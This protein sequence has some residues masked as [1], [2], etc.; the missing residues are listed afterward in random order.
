MF[1]A[2]RRGFVENNKLLKTNVLVS[3]ILVIGFVLTAIFSYRANYQASLNNIEQVSSL[4][5]EGI[6]YQLASLFSK[7]VNISLTMAHD[8]LLVEHLGK[9]SMH[10]EDTEYVETIK[11][12]LRAYQKKYGFDSVF[13][14][15]TASGRYYNFNGMDRVLEK[16]NPENEWYFS[17]LEGSGEYFLNVDNDE[18][19]DANNK[20]TA[21]VNCKIQGPDEGIIG[22]VGVGIRMD[23]LKELLSEYENKFN[24]KV[25][26]VNKEGMIEISTT[27]TGY[28][29]TDWFKAYGQEDLRDEILGWNEDNS[30]L[31]IWATT[32]QKQEK[33]FIVSRY[34]P[35]LSWNLIVAQD[36]GKIVS[37]M[38][39]QIYLNCFIIV[40]VIL[41]VLIVIT[42]V[43][44]NFNRQITNLVEER[45]VMFKKATEQLYDSIYEFNLTKNC[46]VGKQTEEYF[47]SL[48][49][50]GMPFDQGLHII[51][52]K[53]IKDEYRDGYVQMFTP[54]N[55]IREY[56][57]G[58]NH[59][60]YDFMMS[61]DGVNYHWIR[62]ETYLFFSEED[63]S[64]HMFSYRKNIDL[65]KQ[66]EQKAEMDEMTGFYTKVAA[67]RLIQKRLQEDPDHLYAFI[68]FDIDNFKQV[69]DKFGHAFGDYCIIRFTQ[70]IRR[71]FQEGDILGRI[72]GDEFAAYVLAPSEEWARNKARE[73]SE[74]LNMDCT[75][76]ALSCHISASIGVA[77]SSD[78]QNNF[79]LLYQ[80]ADKALY[81]TKQR[82]KNGFTVFQEEM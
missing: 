56:E 66:K 70:T 63:Q 77:F 3:I 61:Q 12:Y 52:E 72:G 6:Y 78:A 49:A 40:M 16:G 26:L 18:V 41:V 80:F 36:T 9:E 29:K 45:Q 69:N 17:L 2:N 60:S 14:V 71:Y 24:V 50:G 27:Y 64:I 15:S 57:A 11:E 4:S 37:Q 62:V 46:Y 59:L 55:A 53:Q 10:M 76:Q 30:N 34:I 7:P 44:R 67:E 82:G 32:S 13:L 39:R 33:S 5:A 35:E 74:V 65:E 38:Q 48:G 43:I 58:N 23:Y 81:Q 22:I 79:E 51:A 75:Q 8:S 47:S 21:F 1:Y 31:E 68:I 54:K 42:T 28:E 19:S 73:L 20:I 25:S